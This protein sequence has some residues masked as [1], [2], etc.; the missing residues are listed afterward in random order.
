M[1]EMLCQ[2]IYLMAYTP[3]HTLDL[4]TSLKIHESVGEEVETLL[5]NLFG[6]MPVLEHRARIEIIP[7]IIEVLDQLMTVLIR[8]IFLGH[9]GQRSR[10]ENVD[11]EH[12]VMGSK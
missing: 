5:T 10:F 1:L 12:R 9:L 2:D 6:I 8:L 7:D 11:D 4:G 3:V